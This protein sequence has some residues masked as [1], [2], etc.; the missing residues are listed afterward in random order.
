ML[1]KILDSV[2]RINSDAF[3]E[4]SHLNN[5]RHNKYEKLHRIKGDILVAHQVSCYLDLPVLGIS[6]VDPGRL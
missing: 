1:C 4:S 5:R 6:G 3:F 2:F